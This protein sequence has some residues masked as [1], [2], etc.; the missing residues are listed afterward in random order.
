MNNLKINCKVFRIN[1]TSEDEKRD[2]EHLNRFLE[3]NPIISIKEEFIR[4]KVD[5][6]LVFV[7]FYKTG[8]FIIENKNIDENKETYKIIKRKDDHD[9]EDDVEFVVDEDLKRKFLE[10]RKEHSLNEG[11][12]LYRIITNSAIDELI[13]NSPSQVGKLHMI[14]GI[15]MITQEKYGSEIIGIIQSHKKGE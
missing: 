7:T 1:M 9:A 5:R 15:G 13:K 11:V 8:N 6:W 3:E 4:G 10:W 12:P 14:K 2:T